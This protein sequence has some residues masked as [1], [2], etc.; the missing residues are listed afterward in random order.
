MVTDD[1]PTLARAQAIQQGLER[2]GLKVRIV[3]QAD[4]VWTQTVTQGDGSGYDL[5][6]SSWQPDFPSANG[7]IQ[8]LF[9]SS[10]VG[11]GGYNLARYSNPEAD[12]LIKRATEETDAETAA[13]EWVEADTLILGDAPVVP[14]I[15]TKNSFLHGSKA[16]NFRIPAFPA[17]P[18]YLQVSLG[19]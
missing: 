18:D 1:A 17:Y 11:D 10:Q 16:E 13:A 7:N 19:Q 15:Y 6:L 14:L 5:T 12:D 9:D 8:P 2:A 3:P 4:D